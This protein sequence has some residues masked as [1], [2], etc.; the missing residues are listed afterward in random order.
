MQFYVSLN[1]IPFTLQ[2]VLQQVIE[3]GSKYGLKVNFFSA[4]PRREDRGWIQVSTYWSYALVDQRLGRWV[5]YCYRLGLTKL[6][7][8]MKISEIMQLKSQELII[9]PWIKLLTLIKKVPNGYR[10]FSIINYVLIDFF[11]RLS[12]SF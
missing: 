7:G 5:F 4:S 1:P 2:T 11:R 12:S 10:I 8:K 3:D 6:H 9:K